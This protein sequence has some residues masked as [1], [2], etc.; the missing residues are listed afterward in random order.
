MLFA[1]VFFITYGRKYTI[2]F[3][4]KQTKNVFCQFLSLIYK[5]K[6]NFVPESFTQNDNSHLF[7]KNFAF[8]SYN[9]KDVK[10]AQWL[11]KKLESYK[12]PTEIHNEFEDS[13]YLRPVFRDQTDLNTGILANTL[14][15]QLEQSKF[16]IVLCSPNSAKSEWVS[17]EVETFIKWGRL[18]C[19]IPLIVDGQP[20]CYNPDLECFPAYLRQWTKEHPEDELLGVSF[21]EVGKEKAFIRV[22]SKMLDVSFDTLWKRHERERRRRIVMICTFT[23]IFLALIYW[24]AVP[25]KL[26]VTLHDADHQLPIATDNEGYAGVLTVGETDYFI[27]PT[28]DADG[29]YRLDTT[30]NMGLMQGYYRGQS[31]PVTFRPVMY[32]DSA[33]IDVPINIGINNHVDIDLTRDDSF[34]HFAGQVIDFETHQPIAGARFSVDD[35]KY[36]SETDADGHFDLYFP[37]EDQ[38]EYKDVII[39]CEGYETFD[40]PEETVDRDVTFQLH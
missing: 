20:N 21:A 40:S 30:L 32:Y 3:K 7:M 5:K 22:V 12:L 39:E 18:D 1:I 19:I 14:H 35:G 13:K 31:V 38:T 33:T 36:V 25:I 28:L 2:F 11:Q 29:H 6:T 23:P 15:D 10:H 27:T 26:S 37:M 17:K 24:L 8:I 34:A 9:H 16:L 4:N